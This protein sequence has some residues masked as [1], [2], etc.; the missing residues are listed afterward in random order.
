M[1]IAFLLTMKQNKFAKVSF[2]IYR[3]PRAAAK[4]KKK[5]STNYILSK[6]NIGIVVYDVLPLGTFRLCESALDID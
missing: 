1:K 2:Y 5:Y 6:Y 3:R 4:K